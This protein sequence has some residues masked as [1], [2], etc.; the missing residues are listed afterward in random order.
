MKKV[1]LLSK[2]V[3]VTLILAL[4]TSICVQTSPQ[5]TEAATVNY[6]DPVEYSVTT[7][8]KSTSNL[9]YEPTKTEVEGR[10]YTYYTVTTSPSPNQ[11]VNKPNVEVKTIAPN[12]KF[13]TELYI[14]NSGK[15]GPVVMITGG[16][17]GN[18]T[19]GYRAADK[20]KNYK[21]TQ[22]TLIVIPIANKPAVEA[23]KRREPGGSDLNRMF[24]QSSAAAPGNTLSKAIYNVVKEYKVDW[25]MDMH[26]SIGYHKDK[27]G[28]YVGQTIIYYPANGTINTVEYIVNELN[29][30][31]SSSIQKFSILRYPVQG[32]LS[33]SSA[34]FLGVSS[35]I[36]ET[37]S[38][39]TLTTRISQQEKAAQ[40]LLSRLGM[41]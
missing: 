23:G 22:G 37:C 34:Q 1:S 41:L 26:E 8:D 2:W 10:P 32:S 15:P 6:V 11:E 29:K 35:F 9:Y 4:F 14:I 40:S 19:A 27:S 39:Q 20:V 18:E 16:V 5:I 7:Y 3:G 36:F 12:T 17:H 38:K 30:G 31:I 13:A 25:L 24:P 28:S 21:I 33:R